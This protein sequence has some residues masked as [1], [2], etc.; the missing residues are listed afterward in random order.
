MCN[1]L[2]LVELSIS[3]QEKTVLHTNALHFSS[4]E[5]TDKS[6]IDGCNEPKLRV[7]EEHE[8]WSIDAKNRHLRKLGGGRIGRRG[9]V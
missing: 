2:A 5:Y 6:T 7:D 4:T 1:Q 9:T 8:E 3:V